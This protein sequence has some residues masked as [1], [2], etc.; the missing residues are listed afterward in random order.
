MF[1][2]KGSYDLTNGWKF[3]P[4]IMSNTGSISVGD[5]WGTL[6]RFDPW[7]MSLYNYTLVKDFNNNSN[8]SLRYTKYNDYSQDVFYN[9]NAMTVVKNPGQVD[10]T[11]N[12]DMTTAE[13]LYNFEADKRNYINVG[14]QNQK[15]KDSHDSVSADYYKKEL[16][17]TSIFVADSFRAS[18]NLDLHAA[19]RSDEDYEGDRDV[20]YS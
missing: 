10:G 17:N 9:D 11:T 5:A 6:E 2:Y 1:F 18:S 16:D 8:L 12:V 14:V 13:V 19:L 7:K 20:S 4:T 15:V 3:K